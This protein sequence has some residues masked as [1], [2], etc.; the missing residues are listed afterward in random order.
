MDPIQVTGWESYRFQTGQVV[1]SLWLVPDP[2]ELRD[3]KRA[4][5]MLCARS[6][7][8]EQRGTYSLP[9]EI[10]FA[11]YRTLGT[12]VVEM[13]TTVS[14]DDLGGTLFPRTLDPTG[15]GQ[16]GQYRL[17]YM[18]IIDTRAAPVRL[19]LP[20]LDAAENAASDLGEAVSHP[21]D[22]LNTAAATVGKTASSLLAPLVIPAIV[23]LVIW[24]MVKP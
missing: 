1:G 18:Q 24:Q 19:L 10:P 13:Y 17:Q 7:L 23:A 15:R 16:A 14:R 5:A 6:G 3:D 12:K 20:A 4:Y 9:D 22:T 11:G 21:L 8:V 2:G